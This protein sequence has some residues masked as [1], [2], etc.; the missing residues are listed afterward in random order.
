MGNAHAIAAVL[1]LALLAAAPA[2]A[3]TRQADITTEDIFALVERGSVTTATKT[4]RP[5]KMAPQAVTVITRQQLDAMGAVTIA[6]A[7]RL[8]PGVNARWSPMGGVFGIRSLGSTPFSSRVLVLID[9]VPYNSPD[10]G[11]LSGHPAY[12]DFFPIEQV[13]RIE[14]L[15]GPGSA[16]Y[17]QNAF[18][19]V[20][21]IITEDAGETGGRVDVSGG[22]RGTGQFRASYG[23]A[24][25]DFAY[26]LT[27]KFKRQEGPMEFQRDSVANNGDGYIK[28]A[29]KGLTLSYLFHRDTFE[30]FTFLSN[31]D[32]VRTL[33]T[34]QTM[35]LLV[36]SHEKRFTPEWRSTLKLLY[37]RRDGSTCA[38]CHDSSG[39]GTFLNGA[40]ATPE[41]IQREHE[42][43]QRYWIN[44]QIDWSPSGSAHKLVFG[45]EYQ[46]DQ[47]A[48]NIV[49]RLDATP[50]IS[51]TGVF[52]QD[53]MS[54][55]SG[56]L[57]GTVGGRL[58]HN[59]LSGTA[60]SPSA[61][62]VYAPTEPFV[63]RGSFGRAFRQPTWND[64]FINQRFLPITLNIGV[65]TELRRVGNPDLSR[66]RISTS[67]VGFEYFINPAY[68][69]KVDAFYSSIGDYIVGDD[70]TLRVGGPPSP[71][72]PAAIGPGPVARLALAANRET[73]IHTSGAEL[74]F[75]A[76]PGA[77]VNGIV[78]YAFQTHDLDEATDS[79]AAYVP[80]HKVTAMVGVTPTER[81]LINFDLSTWSRFNAAVPGLTLGLVAA[82]PGGVLFGERIG[83]PFALGNLNVVY[84]L[85]AGAKRK[86]GVSFQ[87]R[88]L[89]DQRVQ[90][91]PVQALD[92]S[93]RGREA[94]VKVS[95]LF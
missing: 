46:H 23:A 68:S 67:E 88:N 6:D 65:P 8:V 62:L 82:A 27:G 28:A 2:R 69:V 4:E 57:I 45:G 33:P 90:Q 12:E 71:P 56:R 19:G 35:N 18:Q 84:Q 64:Y 80:K 50:N 93:L 59:E 11:G 54:W 70:F 26:S 5:L 16:L 39:A 55:L 15:K 89:F 9:G 63:V 49:E 83:D 21:N 95:Y 29:F 38:N 73:Q 3:Q 14:V 72:R 22:A 7:L 66:E 32:P 58:D 86:V 85:P 37:N 53:E 42:T 41:I 77:R 40:F 87:L 78:S 48:K 1:T 34:E 76:K 92:V 94:F 51:G 61:S 44:E 75:R 79:Q 10:K 60:L 52:A 91:N 81:L 25:S 24:R 31:P 47:S 43:N 17:G 20:V 30:P 13:K 36:A 74:E